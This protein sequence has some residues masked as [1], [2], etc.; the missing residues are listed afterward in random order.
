MSF[1]GTVYRRRNEVEEVEE[2]QKS[3]PVG[4]GK[5]IMAITGVLTVILVIC[6]VHVATSNDR[7]TFFDELLSTGGAIRSARDVHSDSSSHTSDSNV[8]RSEACEKVSKYIRDSM[9]SSKDPCTD[10][11]DYACGGWI[12]KNPIPKTSSTYSTFAKL[13]GQ[14]EKRLRHLLESEITE[15]SSHLLQLPRHLYQSCLDVEAIEKRKGQP[16]LDLIE[17][18]GSWSINKNGS[19]NEDK[20]EL[21]ERLFHIHR[22]FTSAGGP[23]FSVH[24][25]DDPVN[26]S[27]HIIDV[28]N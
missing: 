12:Q 3:F 8:C 15:N 21:M 5:R 20:W 23:L 6:V 2:E 11:F 16:L 18:M 19:W 13:N 14:V 25:S 7:R 1:A 9:D 10:F 26:N 27:Q 17:E 4:C 22:S 24:I 28:S